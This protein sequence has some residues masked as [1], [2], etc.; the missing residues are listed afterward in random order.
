VY[1]DDLY[2]YARPKGQEDGVFVHETAD[3]L[4]ITWRLGHLEAGGQAIAQLQIFAAGPILAQMV[5]PDTTF[6]NAGFDAGASATVGY[7]AGG[8]GNDFQYSLDTPG[9]IPSGTVLSIV[10]SQAVP[11]TIVN[12]IPGRFRP[13]TSAATYFNLG[14]DGIVDINTLVGNLL[15]PVGTH[16][17][18]NNGVFSVGNTNGAA[19]TNDTLPSG[20]LAGGDQALAVYWDDLYTYPRPATVQAD[21]VYVEQ[22]GGALYVTWLVGHLE[23]GGQA[24]IQLQVFSS[25]PVYAQYVYPTLDFVNGG[26][27]NGASATIGYQSGGL[28]G[29]TQWS[30]NTA[31]AVRAG[32]VLSLVDAQGPECR[33]DFNRDGGVNSQ[34]FFDFLTQFFA[35]CP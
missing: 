28:G 5:Y 12:T 10:D 2:T 34:D 13:V 22:T 4:Y 14:D 20:D 18:S 24:T 6:E 16:Q 23:A 32:S 15:V 26:F 33:A 11:V 27:N 25:G 21:G 7:Q 9:S 1:W 17:I 8:F 29:F 31:N 3:T 30:F 19:F 35:G